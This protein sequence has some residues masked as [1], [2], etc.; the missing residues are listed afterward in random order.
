MPLPSSG[1]ISGSQIANHVIG[2]TIFTNLSLGGLIDSASISGGNPDSYSE[3]YGWAP[4]ATWSA[5]YVTSRRTS[6]FSA[7]VLSA[8]TQVYHDGAGSLPVAGDY[9]A[10]T[11]TGAKRLA[12][13]YYAMN[14]SSGTPYQYIIVTT[15]GYVSGKFNCTI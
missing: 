6:A 11:S 13:G 10:A 5:F 14:Q 7:C 2:S 4:P 9:V 3:F 12:G 1:P 15:N 8:T